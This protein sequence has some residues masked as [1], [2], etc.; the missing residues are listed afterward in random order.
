VLIVPLK[1]NF[2]FQPEYL[3]SQMGGKFDN[4]NREFAI[5]YASLPVL[6]KWKFLDKFSL[7][8]GPQFD[9]LINAKEKSGDIRSSLDSNIEHRS[10][11][12][13]GGMEYYFNHN[14][15]LGLKYMQGLNH[16]DI[17]DEGNNIEFKYDA[18]QFALS[19]LF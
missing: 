2:Y 13:T 9:L 8:A 12:I 11:L 10:I 1:N 7:V 5:H 16:I 17:Q 4:E 14:L 18:V 19:Y 3:Y 15:F 6:L